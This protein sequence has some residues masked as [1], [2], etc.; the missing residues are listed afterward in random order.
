MLPYAPPPQA[1]TVG[2][3]VLK[4]LR[5]KTLRF[6]DLGGLRA[7]TQRIELRF[8]IQNCD[9]ELPLGAG[10][11]FGKS[12]AKTLRFCVCIWKATKLETVYSYDV[13]GLGIFQLHTALE[14]QGL[15]SEH[16]DGPFP[17]LLRKCFA[18][19][20]APP[21]RSFIRLLDELFPLQ[22]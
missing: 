2:V 17:I 12:V 19:L 11:R 7:K 8:A 4:T 1:C 21:R 6:R 14:T 9:L 22:Y 16:F 10:M 20:G 5:S 15:L 3:C 13:Q 18:I